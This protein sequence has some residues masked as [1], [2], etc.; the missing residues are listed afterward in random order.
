M[1][2]EK[3]SVGQEAGWAQWTAWANNKGLTG[4]QIRSTRLRRNT[5]HCIST[6]RESRVDMLS[7]ELECLV[8][9][10]SCFAWLISRIFRLVLF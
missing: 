10:Q 8:R 2:H 9:F 6:G 1:L 5:V 7:T 4:Q 3:A